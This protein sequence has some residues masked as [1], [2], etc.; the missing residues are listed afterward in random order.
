MMEINEQL[1]D[2]EGLRQ[3]LREVQAERDKLL[4]S[5][6]ALQQ[7]VEE[8]REKNILAKLQFTD[9]TIGLSAELEELKSRDRDTDNASRVATDALRAEMTKGYETGK[10]LVA[11]IT[12]SHAAETL[13]FKLQAEVANI[14]RLQNE[15][16]AVRQ[17]RAFKIGHAITSPMRMLRRIFS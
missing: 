1:A 4:D 6:T 5:F 3:Q 15:L 10:L 11:E 7:V 17:S 14:Q 13:V 12:K 9:Y 16:D 8:N 2:V